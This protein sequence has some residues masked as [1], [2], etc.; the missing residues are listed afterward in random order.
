M[1]PRRPKVLA[2][3]PSY[4]ASCQIGVI[5]P[6]S[7]LASRRL[8]DL[9]VKLE[10][11]ASVTAIHQADIVVFCRNTE[12][13][14]A[15]LLNEAVSTNKPI[16]YDLDDN[17]WDVPFET[18]PELARYHRLPLRIQQLEKYLTHATLVRVYS[19]VMRELV[20]R[21]NPAVKLL[22]AGFD[23]SLLP[24]QVQ[25]RDSRGK[26][27]V[28]YATSRTVDNQYKLF[29]RGMTEA[30]CHFGDKVEFTIWGCSP[31]DLAG[32]KGIK[33]LPL[34]GDYESFLHKFARSGFDVGLAPME[35][36]AFYRSKTNTK[37]RDYGA[38]RVAGIYSDV[39]VYSSCVEDG[40]TGLLVPNT[41]EGWFN[42]IVK[43]VDQTDLR[44]TIQENAYKKVYE[45][46]RQQV[47]EEEWLAQIQQIL[48]SDTS[49]SLA[50]SPLRQVK[51]VLIRADQDH[52]NGIR[53]PAYSPGDEVPVPKLF[54]EILT[55]E[56]NLLREAAATQRHRDD[57]QKEITFS[58]R[59]IRN[60]SHKEFLLRF[61]S[62]P[63][64]HV[65][66]EISQ[67]LPSAGF[68]HMRYSAPSLAGSLELKSGAVIS[69]GPTEPVAAL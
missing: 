24:S 47:I 59:P 64:S 13:S 21:L 58:F 60:S 28:V 46:Y 53:F 20:S 48:A 8:L 11:K 38:C 26:I 29:M 40:K 17:F 57:E 65:E 22:K 50:N 37:L 12:P 7:A 45:E 49:Y 54:L 6:L 39:E 35:D 27:R 2:I 44:T 9:D 33:I 25:P 4:I 19:P 16:I 51:E 63:E 62:I 5:K 36:T 66:D 43:L 41:D 14:Y 3:V 52:L 18:D 32:H 30:L 34:I 69:R 67:W 56:R 10:T 31:G 61:I 1:I 23:F 68:I 42:A 15:Y 55:P